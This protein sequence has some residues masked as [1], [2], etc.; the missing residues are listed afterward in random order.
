M[1]AATKV[2]AI[3]GCTT[4]LEGDKD[5][6][7]IRSRAEVVCEHTSAHMQIGK[8]Q[9]SISKCYIFIESDQ[10]PNSKYHEKYMSIHNRMILVRS[11]STSREIARDSIFWVRYIM[12][13]TKQGLKWTLLPFPGAL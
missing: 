4:R 2:Y 5:S 7:R 3:L 9:L 10:I 8:K 12:C 1:G 11:S 6:N 13:T